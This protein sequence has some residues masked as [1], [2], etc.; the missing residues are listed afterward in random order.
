METQNDHLARINSWIL[1]TIVN[2]QK[3]YYDR[4][5]VL[6][7]A[8]TQIIIGENQ[9]TISVP[10]ISALEKQF[11]GQTMDN[12]VGGT[13]RELAQWAKNEL[14]KKNLVDSAEVYA[15]A[16]NK[17]AHYVV[18]AKIDQQNYLVDI[19]YSQPVLEAIPVDGLM[20]KNNLYNGKKGSKQAFSGEINYM[21][22]QQADGSILFTVNSPS[23]STEF[24]LYPL[25]DELDKKI[26]GIWA[27]QTG[28]GYA[29]KVRPN[30]DGTYRVDIEPMGGKKLLGQKF[31]EVHDLAK[32]Y[33]AQAIKVIF[34]E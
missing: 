9:A 8:H 20:H 34:R 31:Q 15:C 6:N 17:E 12:A 30:N 24:P 11:A 25:N 29:T 13:C 32:K 10:N 2:G 28:S 22:K 26:P 33:G 7:P 27:V 5:T 1:D 18:V 16:T 21:T 4:T 23:R 3:A 19:G 14:I